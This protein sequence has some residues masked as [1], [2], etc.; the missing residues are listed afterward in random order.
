MSSGSAGL[1]RRRR[2]LTGEAAGSNHSRK[3]LP[4]MDLKSAI[5]S[6]KSK[7]E[8]DIGNFF[9]SNLLDIKFTKIV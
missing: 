5:D 7:F 9:Q 2:P 1:K 8:G 6:A 3:S 4:I